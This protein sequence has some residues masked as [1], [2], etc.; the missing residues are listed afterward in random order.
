MEI[1]AA[2]CWSF[3]PATYLFRKGCHKNDPCLHVTL[4]TYPGVCVITLGFC[5]LPHLR[6]FT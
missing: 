6:G 3:A 5:S 1:W 4:K 2:L